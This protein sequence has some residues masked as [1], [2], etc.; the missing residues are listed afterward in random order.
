MDL[1][2]VLDADQLHL[3]FEVLHFSHLGIELC[4]ELL[5]LFLKF[6]SLI[7]QLLDVRLLLFKEFF[8][9][10]NVFFGELTRFFFFGRVGSFPILGLSVRF[11]LVI[12][13]G[14]CLARRFGFLLALLILL[15]VGLVILCRLLFLRVFLLLFGC[16]F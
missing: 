14:L 4:L 9:L 11:L 2:G 12:R 5:H 6:L 10:I 15:V 13:F 16:F 7:L 1:L 3:F 8:N